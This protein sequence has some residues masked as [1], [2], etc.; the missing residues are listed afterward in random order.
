MGAIVPEAVNPSGLVPDSIAPN[1]H[2]LSIYFDGV[3][4][5]NRL[6]NLPNFENYSTYSLNRFESCP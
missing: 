2:S 5:S 6:S 3:R 1:L 4:H